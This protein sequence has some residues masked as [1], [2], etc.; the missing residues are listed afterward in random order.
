MHNSLATCKLSGLHSASELYR[1][2]DSS[3]P[4]NLVSTLADTRLLRGQCNGSPL[5]LISVFKTGDTTSH[6]S[7]SSVIL[8]RLC[9]PRSR[10]LLLRETG[11]A[12]DGTRDLWVCSQEV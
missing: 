11:S 6:S 1:L 7:S 5:P 2:S 3:W 9:G 4:V 12:G 8:T 10:L